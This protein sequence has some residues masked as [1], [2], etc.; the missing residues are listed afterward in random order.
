MQKKVAGSFATLPNKG[1]V[2]YSP[3]MQICLTLIQQPLQGDSKKSMLKVKKCGVPTALSLP[4]TSHTWELR[5]TGDLL[6]QNL[7]T[8]TFEGTDRTKPL[9]PHPPKK[10]RWQFIP[11]PSVLSHGWVDLTTSL[12]V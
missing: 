3:Y 2:W 9:T 6:T 7:A 12:V 1:P 5:P 8:V 4:L 10:N 11:M